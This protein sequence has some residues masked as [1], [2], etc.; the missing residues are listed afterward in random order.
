M[1]NYEK[2]K[3]MSIDELSEFLD[4]NWVH[5]DDP[6]MEWWNK[7]YCSTCEPVIK[8]VEH[9]KTE[10]EFAWCELNCKCRYYIILYD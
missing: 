7:N 8:R 2:I 4:S 6:C 10:I 5:E 3:A 1:T 9:F